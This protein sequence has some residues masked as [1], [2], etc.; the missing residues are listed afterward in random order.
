LN[1]VNPSDRATDGRETWGFLVGEGEMARRMRAHDWAAT[2]LGPPANWPQSLKTVVRIMLT[3]RYAMWMGWGEELAFFYN[4]A[5]G[6][7]LGVKHDWALGRPAS[8]VWAEIWPDIGPL[9][10]SV[11]STGQSSWNEGLLLLLERSGEPEETYHTFSYSPL[12][13][14]EGRSAGM[15]CV[16]MEETQRVIG[17]RRLDTLRQLASALSAAQTE[18]QVCEAACQALGGNGRDLPFTLLYLLD[19]DGRTARLAGSCGVQAEHA[20]AAPALLDVDAPPGASPWPLAAVLD[21]EAARLQVATAGLGP[22]PQGAWPAPPRQAVIVP[23]RIQGQGQGRAA[24]CLIAGLNPFRPVDAEYTGFVE[25]AASQLA[26]GLANARAYEE[27][28]KQ[29][30]ALAQIDRAKTVFFSN[31]SHEFRT[32]LT[33][34]LGPLED[35]LAEPSLPG[36]AQEQLRLVHRNGVRLLKLVNSLLDFSRIESGRIQASYAPVDLA[37]LTADLASNFRSATERAGLRLEIDCPPLGEPVYVDADMWEKVVLNLLS[38]A[39]KFTFEGGI[40][41]RLRQLGDDDGSAQ[42]ELRVTD[43]GTGIPAH[44]LPR[45]FERFHRIEGA[46]GRSFEG[47]GIGL[48]LVQELV[49][50]HGGRITVDST[51]GQGTTFTVRLPMGSAHLPRDRV[52]AAPSGNAPLAAA[53]FVQEALSWLPVPAR[54]AEGADTSP[55]PLADEAVAPAAA[56]AAPATRAPRSRLLVADDNADMRAYVGRLLGQHH[57]CITVPDG[58]AALE[59]ARRERPDLVLTDIMMPRLDGFGLIRELRA[60]PSLR[61]VPIIALSARAGEEAAIEGL[62]MGADDYLVKPFSARELIARVDGALAIARIR[63]E[64]GEALRASEERFRKMADHAPVMIWTTD[65]EGCCTYLSQ[66]WYDYTGQTPETGL[67]FGW[68]D[69]THPDDKPESERVFLQ[70]NARRAPF[71]LEYRL[72]RRDGAWRWHL[73]AAAPWMG[74]DGRF[75][76]YIGSVIDITERR[77]VEEVQRRLN[78]VLEERITEALWQ[79]E[80]TEAQL[81]QAQKMEAVGKLTGGVA[82][83]FNNLLQVIAGNLQLLGREMGDNERAQARLA[84]AMGGVSRGAKLAAQLLAFARRQPLAPTV[85]SVGRLIRNMDDMLRRALGEGVELETVIGGGLW[86]TL[87]DAAQLENAILNLAINS[88]DAMQ[89]HGR[90]TIEAGNAALDDDYAARH[91]DVQA[92]QYVM[93]AVTDT[94]CGMTAELMEKVFEP[95]FTTKPEGA[96]TGLGLSMV[97][98]FVK[99]SGGHVKLYS[100]PGEGTTVRLYLPRSRQPE[101]LPAEVDAGPATGGHETVLVV[102]DDEEVRQTVVEL[103]GE[104]GY[105]VLKARDADAALVILDS[106]VPIDLLFTDVVMPGRLRSPELARK[107]RARRPDIAVL[108]T[109]GYTENAIVHGGRLD[110]GIELLSKPYTREA[111]ARKVRQVL[112]AR[113]RVG[114]G[115]DLPGLSGDQAGPGSGGG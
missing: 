8:Q 7:T 76:G 108:F 9:V 90:L 47:S 29:A 94:G 51:E 63:R 74:A 56:P 92:G 72:R 19:A 59:L 85:V 67:G 65:P 36:P 83:D 66:S 75:Q 79:R 4:D 37:A 45:M 91:A 31:V 78:Q 77:E 6:P 104:L 69:A 114:T 39:F 110:E 16:V 21:G 38:N 102:E 87:V 109:S 28:R 95:F 40:T 35:T 46:R 99:Q 88:R 111:L 105:R 84:K 100:E 2:P 22:L 24:G 115:L 18:Q 27:A 1:S 71:A 20:A 3:S 54:E 97:Y 58:L 73:D 17:A 106:G 61:D 112:Q 107:A 12:A 10:D 60:D 50:L 113:P 101:D 44:E 5:Y 33:L 82:H 42:A 11:M 62:A 15:F 81:R 41:V 25:L 80:Q 43:T 93:V 49:R 103:L 30:E 55:V 52:R 53:S 96:G 26:A 34:M 89:G 98:G 13:D 64:A 48:A 23:I 68:L 14:D 32:P 70:A 57:D 86:N